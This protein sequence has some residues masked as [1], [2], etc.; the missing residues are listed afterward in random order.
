MAR[1]RAGAPD[2]AAPR[3]RAIPFSALASHS[4]TR[5]ALAH[6]SSHNEQATM[7]SFFFPQTLF[8]AAPPMV[9]VPTLLPPVT[10]PTSGTTF[11]IGRDDPPAVKDQVRAYMSRPRNLLFLVPQPAAD[12]GEE[13]GGFVV[14]ETAGAPVFPMKFGRSPADEVAPAPDAAAAAATVEVAH[15][16]PAPAPHIDS[17]EFPAL[18]PAATKQMKPLT[19]ASFKRPIAEPKPKQSSTAQWPTQQCV[20]STVASAA[21]SELI[22]LLF[23][24][25]LQMQLQHMRTGSK[26]VIANVPKELPCGKVALDTHRVLNADKC[27][28]DR[29][30]SHAIYR[31]LGEAVAERVGHGDFNLWV[32]LSGDNHGLRVEATLGWG[33]E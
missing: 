12:A 15:A 2:S 3:M 10:F 26:K 24:G 23:S 22:S 18:G 11:T 9:A 8:Y 4:N 32:N 13:Q 14:G 29:P 21:V 19:V 20:V 28:E 1:W 27:R 16:T 31:R 33:A 7:N 6:G 5:G 25:D 17:S 30:Y